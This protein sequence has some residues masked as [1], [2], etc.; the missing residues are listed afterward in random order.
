[1]RTFRPHRPR[2]PLSAAPLLAALTGALLI[3]QTGE[4]IAKDRVVVGGQAVS[5]AQHPWV[6]ALSSR[7]VFGPKRSGQFCGG[8]VVDAHTVVTAAHCLST[9]VLGVEHSKVGD[10]KV[11]SGR[12]EINGS[13]GEELP[14]RKVWVNPEFNGSSDVGDLAVLT[15]DKAF[16]KNSAVPMAAEGDAAYAPGTDAR[17]YGWGDTTG[18][19]D[20]SSSL[21]ASDVQVLSDRTCERAYTSGGEARYK[22]ESMLCAGVTGGGRDACQG[23]SGGPLVAKGRLVG[24]VSWGAGCGEAGQPGVYTRISAV[25][26]KIKEQSS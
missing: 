10:L 1:M 17:V 21:R 2:R 4:A 12:T 16:S 22:A 25:L 18:Q 11:I 9:K 23:D 5:T 15:V 14:V 6:V 8:A 13:A 3:P 20:Y 26:A 24:L 19:A 7:S